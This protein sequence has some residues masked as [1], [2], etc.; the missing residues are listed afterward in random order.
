ML[1]RHRRRRGASASSDHGIAVI[2]A[3]PA[4]LPAPG[5]AAT[6]ATCADL[7]LPALGVL[8]VGYTD[9][10]L[11]AR[12]FAARSGHRI[13]ANQELLA[14]GRGQPRRRRAARLPGQQQR[15]PHRAR[16]RRRAA[17]RQLYSLVALASVVLACCSSLGPLLA[18]VPDRGARRDRRLRRRS[19]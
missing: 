12:A 16:R 1:A 3:V 9:N 19:G 7:L 10:V 2:G 18:D 8:L 17:A 11:T 4:G 13:D 6:S 15:Q 14:L 5:R